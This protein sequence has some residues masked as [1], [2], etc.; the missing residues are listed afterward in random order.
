MRFWRL[1]AAGF[2]VAGQRRLLRAKVPYLKSA[3]G[4]RQRSF[5]AVRAIDGGDRQLARDNPS[6]DLESG[7]SL[8]GAAR[9]GFHDD[10]P[11]G[12]RRVPGHPL[13]MSRDPAM[14]ELRGA[15]GPPLAGLLPNP[16][17]NIVSN[18]NGRGDQPA[19]V[20]V[21]EL[22]VPCFRTCL[23]A[24]SRPAYRLAG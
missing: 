4:A 3:G 11:Q 18:A 12:A 17:S 8:T 13:G 14:V 2:E 22:R 16:H 19:A 7:S 24:V 9:Q 20:H 23:S 5:A 10:G 21:V 6:R 1:L 15:V